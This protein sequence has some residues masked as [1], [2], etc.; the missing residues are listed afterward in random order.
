MVFVDQPVGAGFSTGKVNATDEVDIAMQFRGFWKNFMDTFSLHGREVYVTG[1]SYAG[2]YVPYIADGFLNQTDSTYYNVKGVMIYD[3]SL[4]YDSIVEEV[5]TLAFTQ[6]NQNDFPFNDT[7][8]AEIT[9]MSAECGYDK[10]LSDGLTF[11]PKG[12]FPPQP[13]VDAKGRTTDA[14]DIF[15]A[16]FNEIFVINPCFDIYQVG[17]LCPIL[18]D[19]LGF[20]YSSFYLPPGFTEPYFNRTDVKQAIHAPLDVNWLICSNEPVFVNDHDLSLPSAVGDGPLKRVTEKTN[21]VVVGHGALDM[22]L[23]LNGTLLTLNNMTWNGAQ[24]F[25]QA[26]TKPF[27][28]PYHYDPL[29]ADIAGAGV[30]GSWQTDRGLTFVSVDLSGH[31]IPEFQPSAAYRHLEFLLG[32]IKNLSEVSAF[33]TQPGFPQ[34]H[35]PLGKGTGPIKKIEL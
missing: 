21:N 27:Y 14:C 11:P 20:P 10:F 18:W 28:V 29:M 1:E 15:D 13:G 23:I 12:P 6:S 33:T 26:P 19:V 7:F 35:Q 22:V 24:G 5:P 2:Q 4:G 34:S 32:R 8:K 17:S 31:E 25:T 9:K 16:V 30:F 3:P